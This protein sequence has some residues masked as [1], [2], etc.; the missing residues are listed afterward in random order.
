MST[1][2]LVVRDSNM[3]GAKRL[4]VLSYMSVRGRRRIERD[5]VLRDFIRG[6]ADT[7]PVLT[8]IMRRGW[9][10]GLSSHMEAF[11]PHGAG[12]IE[13]VWRKLPPPADGFSLSCSV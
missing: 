2:M 8:M 13:L 12:Q 6:L 1:E 10:L 5:G 4:R 3:F 9:S 11:R 7:S